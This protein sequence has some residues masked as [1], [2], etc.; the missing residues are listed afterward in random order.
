MTQEVT[1]MINQWLASP[2]FGILLSFFCFVI[3]NIIYQR[4]EIPLFIPLLF[5]IVVI[6]SIL[7]ALNIPYETYNI[8]GKYLSYWI[9]PATI[10]L[11]IGLEKNIVYLKTYYKEIFIGI[12]S[13]IIFH[14][15]LMIIFCVI[16]KFQYHLAASLISKPI[17]T[18]IAMEVTEFL[19]GNIPLSVAIVV[20]TGVVGSTI[21][22]SVLKYFKITHPIAQGIAMGATS[23][24]VGTA[25]ALEL[26]ATQGAMS[27]LAIA[28]TGLMMVILSPIAQIILNIIF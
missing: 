17:T 8:G 26:G 24:A 21:G 28:I 16:F 11:A 27:G 20:F 13:G 10:A 9:T 23:H 19:G 7:Y 4:F 6:I 14:T 3:G 25:K 15:L 1:M 22:P 5:S 18:P 2:Y 12:V